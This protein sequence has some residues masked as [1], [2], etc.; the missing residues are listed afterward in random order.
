MSADKYPCIF[1]RQIEIIVYILAAIVIQS[2][3][4]FVP[5]QIFYFFLP[6]KCIHDDSVSACTQFCCGLFP[7]ICGI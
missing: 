6:V 1:S 5:D 3:Q 7:T 4:G 2:L